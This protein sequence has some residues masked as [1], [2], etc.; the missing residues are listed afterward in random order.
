MDFNEPLHTY[1]RK[2]V[3]YEVN[4]RQFTKE[5]SFTS[6]QKY[7]PRLK[8]MGVTIIWLMPIHPIGKKNRKGTLGSYYSIKNHYEVNPEFGTKE[9]FKN[10]ISDIHTLGMKVIIDWVANHVSCDHEWSVTHPSYFIKNQSGEYLPAFDWLDVIQINHQNEDA[11]NAMIEAM[12]YWV[13]EFDI[14]G[15]RADLAHLT[16][17]SFWKKS[18]CRTESIKPNLIWLAETEDFSFF[19]VF[20]IIYTWKW[21]HLTES[22]FKEHN[23]SIDNLIKELQ[24]HITARGED[25]FYLF[26]TSNHDENSWNGTEYEKYGVYAKG[27]AVL[28][29]LFQPSVPLIYS[30]QEIPNYRRL[31][32]FEKD[33]IDWSPEN[34]LFDFYKRLAVIRQQYASGQVLHFIKIDQKILAYKSESSAGVYYFFFNMDQIDFLLQPVY[35]N[36]NVSLYDEI[37]KVYIDLNVG[38]QKL[39]SPGEFL[40]INTKTSVNNTDVFV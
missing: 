38:N 25:K 18:K 14:D 20:D 32:F 15:F 9:N 23:V 7:L 35:V 1:L 3:I 16:P 5:G 6:F 28:S 2:S 34:K 22:F 12:C 29:F 36:H 17:L 21:M 19:D 24:Y 11:H 4:I 39:L 27:L 40:V 33:E 26:F 10:L 37:N 8:K 31:S 30:G 13:H